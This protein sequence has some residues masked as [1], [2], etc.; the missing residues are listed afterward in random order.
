MATSIIAAL[1]ESQIISP[2]GAN[3]KGRPI[4][5]NI[6]TG[7]K[8]EGSRNVICAGAGGGA[9]RI[10]PRAKRDEPS[11]NDDEDESSLKRKRR[12]TSVC[13]HFTPIVCFV[14]VV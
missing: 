1:Q 10:L 4:E 2:S 7:M 13:F 5:I 14:S 9:C 8:I 11:H 3:G 12:A 6:D